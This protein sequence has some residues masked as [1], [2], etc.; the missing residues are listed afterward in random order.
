MA[1]D[2]YTSTGARLTSPQLPTYVTS[3]PSGPIDGQEVYYAADA[4]NGVIWHLRYRSA[5]SSSYKWEF[6]GGP[7]MSAYNYDSGA[8]TT[9][10]TAYTVVTY[11]NPS[12]T[13]PLAGDYVL[14]AC[15]GTNIT[16]ATARADVRLNIVAGSS[17]AATS[18]GSHYAQ[19]AMHQHSVSARTNNLA[20]STVIKAGHGSSVASVAIQTYD[21]T[22]EAIPVRV[23]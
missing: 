4:T 14:R 22:I 17:T 20:A 13:L 5:S 3:L 23:G 15:G 18:Y 8:V 7:P 9:S 10:G 19:Y 21:I 6:V 11:T 16:G 2:V 12:L 1:L